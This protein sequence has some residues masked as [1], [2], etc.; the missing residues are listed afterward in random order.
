MKQNAL[1][2]PMKTGKKLI[3]T[4]A[5]CSMMALPAQSIFANGHQGED[6]ASADANVHASIDFM[7]NGSLYANPVDEPLPYIN[8][9]NRTMVPVR[10]FAEAMGVSEGDIYWDSETQTTM[11]VK[12][13]TEIKITLGDNEM[14]KNDTRIMM[15]TEA[16]IQDGRI[17]IPVRFAAEGLG[18]SVAW[19]GDE[20]HIILNAG[21]DAALSVGSEESS[22]VN[23]EADI[24]GNVDGVL[25]SDVLDLHNESE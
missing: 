9:D 2:N 21:V 15:D 22:N 23:V 10:F 13:D 4:A 7:I 20:N 3:A 6:H 1:V 24:D 11:M 18:A 12:G 5:I 8:Q 19:D 16:E 17:F 25:N 14:W